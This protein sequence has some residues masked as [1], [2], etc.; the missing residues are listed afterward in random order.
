MLDLS[1]FAV[2]KLIAVC[3]TLTLSIYQKKFWL[4]YINNFIVFYFKLLFDFEMQREEE[5]SHLKKMKGDMGNIIDFFF[6]QNL[7]K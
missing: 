4:T 3:D 6:F 7:K 1:G 5:V 2:G